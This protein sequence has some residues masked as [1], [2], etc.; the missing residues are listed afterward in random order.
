MMA[1]GRI[2]RAWA[3]PPN[4]TIT[5]WAEKNV[6]LPKGQSARPGPWITESYQREILDCIIDPLVER[7]VFRKPT[8]VGWSAILNNVVGYFIDADAKPQMMVQPTDWAAKA[9]STKRIAPL[10]KATECLRL[11]VRE[12]RSRDGS[13]SKLLKEYD[14]GFLKIGGAN[15]GASLRSDP[16]AILLLDEV[17][18]YPDDV[19]GE[20]NPIEIAERR[21]ETFD[22]AKIFIGSTPAKP[23]G[24]S[25]IDS[26]YE[27]SSQGLYHVPCPHCGH[28]QPLWWR[29]PVTGVHRLI[30]DKDENGDVIKESVR[31]ICA[32]CKQGIDEKFKQRMLDGGRW[33]HRFPERVSIRGFHLNSLY[34]PW[35]PIWAKMATRWVKAKDNPDKLKTFINLS[36]AE[37]F[38]E[39]GEAVETHELIKRVEKYIHPDG[40]EF[41]VP[42]NCCVLVA[43][44]DVQGNRLEVQI[45]GFGP[46]EESWL[47]EHE[48]FWGDPG[49]EEVWM[50]LDAFLNRAYLHEC[51][52]EIRPALCLIDS[53]DGG[54]SDSVYD[55]VAP[56]QNARH[57][58]FACKGVDYLSKP[59]LAAEGTTKR[60]GIRLWTVA[61]T[62][63]KD[64]IYARLKIAQPGPGYAHYPEWTTEEYFDQLTAE[65]KN[66]I[67]NRTTR[68]EKFVYVKQHT[69]NE[70]LDLTVYAHAGLFILQTFIGPQIYKDLHRL[71]AAVQEG[72]GVVP[73]RVRRVRSNGV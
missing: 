35:R 59:G 66:P 48:V 2:S 29:D 11:K 13:N 52:G 9:Y 10:I 12:A 1:L 16:V 40:T 39:G 41:D 18:G 43:T 17:E 63:A 55:Y 34:S 65:K 50:Q 57:R 21:T 33:V 19:D 62:A 38:D 54:H 36:L 61:T 56:R 27:A 32:G 53:G 4:L 49:V 28:V 30:Y 42:R 22:D 23:R 47:I 26:E 44:V 70:A 46:G 68:R 8:Q 58:V 14:G 72:R 60:G 24:F 67:R 45:T 20:G 25:I 51:G 6:V 71:A 64:R 3:P 5:E 15:S 31:Y 69:R 73:Q 37:T 7:V